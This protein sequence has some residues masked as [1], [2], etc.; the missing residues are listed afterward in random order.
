MMKPNSIVCP[1]FDCKISLPESVIKHLMSI[2]KY[3]MLIKQR[4]MLQIAADKSLI[5]CPY[6]SCKEVIKKA[7]TDGKF[8]CPKCLS[9][10]CG[11]C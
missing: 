9:E 1:N 8:K 4:K 5:I 11:K 10:I 3:Q 6:E 7:K 2:D